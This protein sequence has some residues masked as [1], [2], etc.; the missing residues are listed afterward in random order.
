MYRAL[1]AVVLP[2]TL[3]IALPAGAGDL[4]KKL[5]GNYAASVVSVCAQSNA[6]FTPEGQ[7]LGVVAPLHRVVETTRTYGGDGTMSLVG[8]SFQ[9]ASSVTAPGSFPVS[10]SDVTCT[11][12]YQ[13]NE[14]LTFAETLTCSGNILSGSAAGLTFT[15]DPIVS[16]GRIHGKKL[17]LS[18]TQ[19][20]P[21]TVLHVAGAPAPSYRL[22]AGSGTGVKLKEKTKD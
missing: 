21:P 8:R 20:N 12:T 2:A 11:G 7:A 9:M 10:E 18:D 4:N 16:R 6:G 3:L 13:V 15:Q 1:S 22:C 17:L 5:K 14:D 19:S